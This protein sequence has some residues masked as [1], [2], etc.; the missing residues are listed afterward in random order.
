MKENFE[1]NFYSLESDAMMIKIRLFIFHSLSCNI[2]TYDS[3]FFI[4]YGG[5]LSV[6]TSS[7]SIL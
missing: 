2:L 4:Y 7:S 1:K 5:T 6:A 3:I